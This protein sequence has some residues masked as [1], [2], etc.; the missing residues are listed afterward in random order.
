MKIFLKVDYWIQ[1]IL[2]VCMGIT[3]PFIFIPLLLL[4]GFGGW[5]LFSG[6]ITFF[7][8]PELKRKGYLGKAIGYLLFL[9]IGVQLVESDL[10]PNFLID[11]MIVNFIFWLMIPLVIGVWYYRMVHKDCWFYCEKE[12]IASN[13][14]NANSPM[15]KENLL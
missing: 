2:L 8:Y 3:L 13:T 1:T 14:M 12:I 4:L 11:S 6:A 9:Y 5:Q 7:C 15:E 10:L